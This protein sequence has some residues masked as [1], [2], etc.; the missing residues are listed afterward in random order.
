MI[1]GLK[2]LFFYFDFFYKSIAPFSKILSNNYQKNIASVYKSVFFVLNNNFC[3]LTDNIHLQ[4]S[5]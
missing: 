1:K 3:I 5:L 4:S 2:N